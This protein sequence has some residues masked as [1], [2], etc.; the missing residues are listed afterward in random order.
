[1]AVTPRPERA[2]EIAQQTIELR[3]RRAIEVIQDS[4]GVGFQAHTTSQQELEYYKDQ[5]IPEG[6]LQPAAFAATLDRI[7]ADNMLE[8]VKTMERDF[9]KSRGGGDGQAAASVYEKN[10]LPPLSGR[11]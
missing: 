1:M 3:V 4:G 10:P 8:L 7:G 6:V 9:A 2:A 5:I 11:M